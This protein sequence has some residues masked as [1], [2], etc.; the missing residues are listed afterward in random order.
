M[1]LVLEAINFVAPKDAPPSRLYPGGRPKAG[2]IA[3]FCDA[4]SGLAFYEHVAVFTG[5]GGEILSL[6][7]NFDEKAEEHPLIKTTVETYLDKMG[8]GPTARVEI[9]PFPF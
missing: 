3:V 8:S 6:Q 2:D 9:C 7:A 4:E 5:N 1:Q